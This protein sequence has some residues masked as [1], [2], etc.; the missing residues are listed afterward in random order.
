MSGPDPDPD[1]V[2]TRGE[3][4]CD[5]CRNTWSRTDQQAG[6][7]AMDEIYGHRLLPLTAGET[8]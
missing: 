3:F 7:D 4:D 5:C 1:S 8:P 6:L 2:W